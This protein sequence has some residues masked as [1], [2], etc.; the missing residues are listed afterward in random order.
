MKYERDTVHMLCCPLLEPSV[1]LL[2]GAIVVIGGVVDSDFE[3]LV[4]GSVFEVLVVAGG[5]VVVSGATP[6]GTLR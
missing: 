6:E 4:V 3:V 2:G 5:V 1:L